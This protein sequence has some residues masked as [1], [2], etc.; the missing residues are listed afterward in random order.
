MSVTCSLLFYWLSISELYGLWKRFLWR[1]TA[2]VAGNGGALLFL[3]R[4]WL[5]SVSYDNNQTR[6][7]P[8]DGIEA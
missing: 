5:A 6:R 7:K 3:K 4:G 1:A 2:G 8:D